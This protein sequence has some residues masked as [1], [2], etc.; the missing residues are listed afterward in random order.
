M[1]R[2]IG[3]ICMLSLAVFSACSAKEPE[4]T[5]V[6]TAAKY[7]EEGDYAKAVESYSALILEDSGNA[8]YYV[9][10]AN[11]YAASASD[12]EAM[13]AAYADYR[14]A[15]ELDQ[16]NP[17]AYTGLAQYFMRQE[18]YGSAVSV[19]ENAVETLSAAGAPEEDIRSL[20][21]KLAGYKEETGFRSGGQVLYSDN[22][23]VSDI[24]YTVVPCEPR[25]SKALEGFIIVGNIC[26]SVRAEGPQ[27]VRFV[28]GAMVADDVSYF[29]ENDMAAAAEDWKE[30]R[31]SV[32]FE[33]VPFYDSGSAPVEE[34]WEKVQVCLMGFDENYDFA[35]YAVIEIDI[36]K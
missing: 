27:D 1:K 31:R 22:L 36:S 24:S 4:L 25:E 13:R 16:L 12:A 33:T 26:F 15:I 17:A 30:N 21:E 9:G 8:D 6:E 35:G 20:E 7:M 28:H 3:C 34:H 32:T 5:A 29:V 23:Q 19:L 2:I 11:A 10:R 18:N 14:K